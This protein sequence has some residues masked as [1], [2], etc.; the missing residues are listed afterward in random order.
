MCLL[1]GKNLALIA[2][3]CVK[4][5]GAVCNSTVGVV[6]EVEGMLLGNQHIAFH[7]PLRASSLGTEQ[8]FVAKGLNFKP[9]SWTWC[10][11]GGPCSQ[12]P[13]SVELYCLVT[14]Y[15]FVA[16]LFHYFVLNL[17]QLCSLGSKSKRM[18][19]GKN[20]LSC[21]YPFLT[22]LSERSF[23]VLSFQHLKEPLENS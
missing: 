12:F 14:K 4:A 2:K 10:S 20:P 18:A 23:P 8:W 9:F 6:K 19:E 11:G 13:L 16:E 17:A 22:G 5:A 3:R 7:L 15:V 1:N 21:C